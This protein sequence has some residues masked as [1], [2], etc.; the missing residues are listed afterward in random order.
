VNK[1]VTVR[2][3]PLQEIVMGYTHYWRQKRDFTD[4]EW[5][6]LKAKS[7]T[8]LKSFTDGGGRLDHLSHTEAPEHW[9]RFN[10]NPG[11]EKFILNKYQPEHFFYGWMSMSEHSENGSFHFCKTRQRPY[12]WAVVQVLRA[13]KLVAPDA[14]TLS[15]DG[16]VFDDV[17][18]N[19]KNAD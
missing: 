9:I 18:N 17:E 8:I 5:T 19:L 11:C 12:D 6:I 14:I 10:G 2:D 4:E 16:D 3:Q 7:K 1:L 15:S 13:A